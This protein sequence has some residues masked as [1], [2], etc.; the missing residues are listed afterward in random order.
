VQSYR[1][2]LRKVEPVTVELCSSTLRRVQL[3]KVAL[4]RFWDVTVQFNS[5][6]MLR[7][8]IARCDSDRGEGQFVMKSN[9][10][11]ML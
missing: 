9:L 3:L 8:S 7:R 6:A 10:E 11:V 5:V 2:Q 1:Q 4:C